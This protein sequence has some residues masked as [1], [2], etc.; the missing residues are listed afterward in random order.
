MT[1]IQRLDSAQLKAI[2]PEWE[3]LWASVPDASPFQHPAW[4]LPWT[5]A[6]APGRM[7]AAALWDGDRLAALLPVF[8]WNRALLLAGT[9]PSDHSSLLGSAEALIHAAAEA[10]AEPFDRIDFQQ[11]PSQSPLATDS[12]EPCMVLELRG[13]AGMAAVS[14]R[15]RSNWRYSVRRLE[16]KGAVIDLVTAEAE[17]AAAD[18]G[19]L[20]ALRW[21]EKGKDGVLSDDLAACHL[22]LAIPQLA[23]AGLLRMHRL[24]AG[25]ETIAILFAMRGG[26]STCFYLSGFDPDWKRLS[27]GNALVGAAIAQAAAESCTEFD[28]LRGQEPYKCKWGA[29]ARAMRRYLAPRPSRLTESACASSADRPSSASIVLQT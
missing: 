21:R 8:V 25:D 4:L 27:P 18:L 13:S 6:Y 9:G 28:F 22:Q 16:R 12:G 5:Q 7:A 20:H 2:R 15:M 24:R 3:S 19:R 23:G 10:V 11:L 17:A 14:K 26:R 29:K 1:R